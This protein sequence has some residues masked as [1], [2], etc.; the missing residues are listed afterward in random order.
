MI[1]RWLALAGVVASAGLAHAD[2]SFEARAQGAH[3]TRIEDL[4][5][6]LTAT[7]TDG[8]DTHQRQCRHARDARRAELASQTVLVD[9][10]ADA[11]D[12]GAW[13]PST[14]TVPF[15]VSACIACYGATD[16][17]KTWYVVASGA[18]AT[19]HGDVF[20]T[21]PLFGDARAF[22]D[23]AAAAAWSRALSNARVELVAKVPAHPQWSQGGKDGLALDVVAWRVVAPC[24]GA[25]IAAKPASGPVEPDKSRCVPAAPTVAHDLPELTA[26]AVRAAMAPVVEAA[27]VCYGKFAVAGNATLVLKILP[28]G[29]VGSY[30]QHGDFVDTPTGM[31]I[32]KAISRLAFPASARGIALRFPL[33]VAP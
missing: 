7:C 29:T 17:G 23:E 28:D 9:G 1:T 30:V 18:P 14:K 22:P 13:N 8:D 15:T 6:T 20:T 3:H 2:E 31:C 10:D 33:S 19:L 21:G 27:K 11:F 4:V 24:D 32:D 16:A 12:I 26:D 25:I 5:W